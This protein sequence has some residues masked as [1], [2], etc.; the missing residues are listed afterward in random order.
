VAM[1]YMMLGNDEPFDNLL[2]KEYVFAYMSQKRRC[3][4]KAQAKKAYDKYL[5]RLAFFK[6]FS[7]MH[8]VKII[9]ACELHLAS[10]GI[11]FIRSGDRPD[12]M[13]ILIEGACE[14]VIKSKKTKPKKTN[15]RD[16]MTNAKNKI[17][18]QS[19]KNL[20]SVARAAVEQDK[21]LYDYK[22]VAEI[23]EGSC[24]GEMGL[25]TKNAVRSASVKA[26]VGKEAA[27]MFLPSLHYHDLV[28][29]SDLEEKKKIQECIIRTDI[30]EVLGWDKEQLRNFCK[31]L[32]PVKFRSGENIS[33][34]DEATGVL[35]LMF[36]SKGEVELENID[37]CSS[38]CG[39]SS[40]LHCGDIINKEAALVEE[41][42]KKYVKTVFHRDRYTARTMVLMYCVNHL[43][44][45]QSM[46][47]GLRTQLGRYVQMSRP[48][49]R[50]A[51]EHNLFEISTRIEQSR[52]SQYP[53]NR[54]HGNF[55]QTPPAV[56]AHRN[57]MAKSA[58]V[59]AGNR[60]LAFGAQSPTATK[61]HQRSPA[62]VKRER[63][64]LAH[65]TI[66][67]NQES[68]SLAKQSQRWDTNWGSSKALK[69]RREK[70][71]ERK[72]ARDRQVQPARNAKRSISPNNATRQQ[73]EEI[74]RRLKLLTL[75]ATDTPSKKVTFG[76]K[77]S[78]GSWAKLPSSSFTN[79][80]ASLLAVQ[81]GVK[82]SSPFKSST[83][84]A[85][86]TKAAQLAASIKGKSNPRE[87]VGSTRRRLS[88][89][90]C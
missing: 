14:V 17:I 79:N 37:A 4:T 34:Y 32:F 88:Q 12:G 55:L 39:Q 65:M 43:T 90:A 59:P 56:R 11:S 68:T 66:T 44:I 33:L 19:S 73:K 24:F 8:A 15:P 25:M 69:K 41:E 54:F 53:E 42:A 51:T 61:A 86:Q 10:P 74:D 7:S 72:H 23:E 20:L 52:L 48:Q 22:V 9:D 71:S 35:R 81:M 18:R 60:R 80:K 13:Y 40:L 26:V 70:E 75:S 83:D 31:F 76:R 49:L 6:R 58:S 27:A 28:H 21:L 82:Q 1:A 2:G 84:S 3:R 36:I 77:S 30:C 87:R 16:A 85:L 78:Q 64:R 45:H 46:P 5:H 47:I 38:K 89:I 63:E 29:L 57:R 62:T 67:S 50:Q